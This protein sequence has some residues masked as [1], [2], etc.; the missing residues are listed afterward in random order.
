MNLLLFNVKLL[1]HFYKRICF[2]V[3]VL[4]NK[5]GEVRFVGSKRKYVMGT[6]IKHLSH[7]DAWD[8]TFIPLGD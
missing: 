3:C 7:S 8:N 1:I 5:D 6:G 2:T 4:L